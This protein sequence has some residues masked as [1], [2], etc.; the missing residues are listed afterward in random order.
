MS[1]S[2]YVKPRKKVVYFQDMS[3]RLPHSAVDNLDQG[4]RSTNLPRAGQRR[5]RFFFSCR[6]HH[7][8]R[9]DRPGA[10]KEAVQSP[11]VYSAD[12]TTARR[13]RQKSLQALRHQEQSL[14]H[15][16]WT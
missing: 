15:S 5:L 3:L 4:T 8:G 6:F 13:L 2:V 10:A 16:G 11:D 9:S 12:Q 1:L 14:R 7:V